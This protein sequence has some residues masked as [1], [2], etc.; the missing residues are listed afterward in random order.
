MKAIFTTVCVAVAI[1]FYTLGYVQL[2]L[3]GGFTY[4]RN[5]FVYML[6]GAPAEHQR[7][8]LDLE[9]DPETG[10]CQAR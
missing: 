7:S 9:C 4:F 3:R 6:G 5:V 1:G 8:T 10:T 2:D